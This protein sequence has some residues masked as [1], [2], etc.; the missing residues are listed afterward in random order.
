MPVILAYN[1]DYSY[2]LKVQEH[3]PALELCTQCSL[4]YNAHIV[5]DLIS[6]V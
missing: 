3:Q 6:T 5:D 4:G 1:Y 2:V